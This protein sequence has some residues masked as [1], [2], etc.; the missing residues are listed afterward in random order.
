MCR[1]QVRGCECPSQQNFK[2]DQH[3]RSSAGHV[4]AACQVEVSALR[5]S[6][7]CLPDGVLAPGTFRGQLAS[8]FRGAGGSGLR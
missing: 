1:P 2:S 6:K 3:I 4:C 8:G 7:A 5:R